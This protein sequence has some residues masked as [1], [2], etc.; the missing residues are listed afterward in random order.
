MNYDSL[1]I[2]LGYLTGELVNAQISEAEEGQTRLIALVSV[3][4][5]ILKARL[6]T[7]VVFRVEVAIALGRARETATARAADHR[8]VELQGA[9]HRV[10]DVFRSRAQEKETRSPCFAVTSNSK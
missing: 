10:D 2:F 9:G 7:A 6:G 3:T 5:N 8:V 4:A 1:N